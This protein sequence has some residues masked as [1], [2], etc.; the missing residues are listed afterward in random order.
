MKFVSREELVGESDFLSL[1]LPL[2]PETRGM[3]D[4]VFLDKMKNGSFLINT[5]RGELVD[6]KALQEALQCGKLQGAALDVYCDQPPTKEH[7]LLKLPQV[8]PTL[9]MGSH[10]DDA[11]NAMGWMALRDCLSVLRGEAPVYRVV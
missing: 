3:I 7:P 5:A 8:L 4:T 11:M 10:T 1:H 2:L 6:E 9:H